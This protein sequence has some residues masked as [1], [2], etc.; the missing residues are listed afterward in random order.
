MQINTYILGGIHYPAF[1]ELGNGLHSLYQYDGRDDQW[2][3]YILNNE[4]SYTGLQ[5]QQIL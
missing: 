2:T 3:L 4:H 1:L 5:L